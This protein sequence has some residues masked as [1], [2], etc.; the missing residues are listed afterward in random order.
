MP[1]FALL[2]A[3]V[4]LIASPATP[5]QPA[6]PE[7]RRMEDSRTIMR[8]RVGHR[9]HRPLR[10][11]PRHPRRHLG[12]RAAPTC[13]RDIRPQIGDT[14]A[15]L[16]GVSATSFSPGASRPVLRGFQGER[17]R[18]LTDGIGSID[19]SNTSADHAV[20]IDPLTAERIE[21]L[22]GPA[23]L[24]FGSQAIG[25][26]VNVLDRRI[27]RVVPDEPFHFARHRR[28]WLG[29]RRAQHRRR[30]RCPARPTAASSSI[31][32]AASARPTT[33][34]VGGFVLS[35]EL[36]AEQL[37]IAAEESGGRPCRRGRRG[38]RAGQSARARSPTARPSR[39]RVGAGLALIRDGGSLGVSVSWFDSDYG[40]PSRPGAEHHHGEEG[41]EG[42]EEE[43]E[44]APVTIGLEQIR[45]DLRGE[46]QVGGGFLDKIRLRL[47][48]RRLRAYRVRGRRGRHGLQQRR[49][50]KAGWSWSR[51]DRNGW[52]GASGAPIFSPRF[53][54]GRRR[55]L[56]AAQRHQPVRPVH[57]S[58]SSSS[59]RSA[60]RRR[61]VTSTPT[62]ARDA[63]GIDRDFN[64][65]SVA[66]GASYEL[67]PRVKFGANVSRAERAPSA[68][69]LF[70]NG[71]HIA[72]QAFEIGDPDLAKEKSWGAE[73][74]VRAET[75][76]IIELS[77][78]RSS[79]TGSTI[80]I[81]EAET[82]EEE[83]ELPVFQYFQRDAT[84]LR[85]R[86]RG[87]GDPVPGRR[88]PLRRRLRRR[89]CARDDQG[90]RPGAAH[91]AVPAARRARG[92]VGPVR[93]PDRGRMG[94]R[95][96]S[97]RRIRK[98]RPTASPWSMPRSPG[99]HAASAGK[100]WS[101]CPPTI[102]SMST[103]GG[104]PASPRISCRSRAATSASARGSA[105]SR[106]RSTFER[107]HQH[108]PAEQEGVGGEAQRR[109]VDLRLC[110]CRSGRR[111]GHRATDI[112]PGPPPARGAPSTSSR[113]PPSSSIT[114]PV[115]SADLD[116]PGLAAA[117][118]PV[119]LGA[120]LAV[121]GRAGEAQRRG[122]RRLP[123]RRDR[124]ARPRARTRRPGRS[125]WRST[126][127]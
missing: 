73:A 25:G 122:D 80:I 14:L 38:A 86:G 76:A 84:L 64:A 75:A 120:E 2:L 116:R 59:A 52:R 43:H 8:R 23:V 54:G 127:R 103:R 37:E 125:G 33:C 17:V 115:G 126:G 45:A 4:A 110:R 42:E 28:L 49:A 29:R 124:S 119:E 53:R 91:P 51:R 68:E 39:R 32:T 13:V 94:R 99:S 34:E 117:V 3:S 101:C 88:L 77:A 92:A 16:P 105:S 60:S 1:R 10:A 62:S 71:P 72:T 50:S 81:F 107:L 20:T 78:H 67:A 61:R 31:S 100:P 97:R 7:Q 66:L 121:G 118:P 63:V 104:T 114:A 70:S 90:R 93:R 47:G 79:P 102:S 123:V 83:D 18:V 85:L 30:G 24:L 87:L 12:A 36:R 96:G 9:H 26:A 11:Q 22:H 6:E 55:G 48:L 106:A 41:E 113:E 56:P 19:V 15:R 40:V 95:S 109:D 82:G 5:Q 89:L 111:I 35:P 58:R 74:Y 44:E 108:P 21:V 57:A 98:R 27:P 65:F 69:E 112:R 46:Y